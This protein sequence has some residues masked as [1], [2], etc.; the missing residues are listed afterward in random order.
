MTNAEMLAWEAKIRH[1]AHKCERAQKVFHKALE[2]FSDELAVHQGIAS[3]N[4]VGGEDK[5][6]DPPE[7]P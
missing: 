2:Q 3:T 6:E 1:L 4:R 7:G 5:P